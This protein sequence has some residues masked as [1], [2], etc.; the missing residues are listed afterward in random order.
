MHT[1]YSPTV[2][3][4]LTIGDAH[5]QE[6]PNY[7][8]LGLR[9]EH[10]PELISLAT[11]AKLFW[12]ESEGREVWAPIHAWRTL[13]QLRATEAIEPLIPMF[14]E[15]ED[16]DWSGEELPEVFGMIG[17]EAIPALARY[18]SDTTHVMWPRL[19][20]AHALERIAANDPSARAEVMAALTQ[21]LE[22]YATNDPE[23]NAFLISYLIDIKAVEAAPL[24]ERIFADDRA[25]LSI[26]G[27]WEDVQIALGLRT[28]RETPRPRYNLFPPLE[29]PIAPAGKSKSSAGKAAA[30]A[31]SK[32]KQSK[33][34]RKKNK[35]K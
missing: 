15:L 11:D 22:Q 8:D 2:A 5:N 14:H 29:L 24:M 30:K 19:T 33:A 32:R 10:I 16:S 7:L 21:P 25:E 31:K 35:R 28:E 18:L 20:A 4:L 26:Q 6:W 12:S 3:K 34:S 1:Q 13:G 17:R 23:L 27:D 9:A